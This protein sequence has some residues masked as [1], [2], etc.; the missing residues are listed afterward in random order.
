MQDCNFSVSIFSSFPCKP[1]CA[2]KNSPSFCNSLNSKKSTR[3]WS[4]TSAALAFSSR[5]SFIC[6]SWIWEIPSASF[7]KNLNS[8][9][10]TRDRSGISAAFSFSLRASFICKSWIWEIPSASFSNNL[11][12]KLLT[13]D[14]SGI[15]AAFSFSLRVSFICKSWICFREMANSL[16]LASSVSCKSAS[17]SSKPVGESGGRVNWSMPDCNAPTIWGWSCWK[18]SKIFSATSCAI[19]HICSIFTN[20]FLL[21]SPKQ[22][23]SI[24]TELLQGLVN[25]HILHCA[26]LLIY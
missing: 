10:L 22:N 24:S 8:K 17:R 15:S 9:L 14:R 6:K 11:N 23:M 3:N 12:S 1:C 13:R 25:V 26:Q 21:P 20:W 5:T 18:W 19:N 7:S 4:G 2:A 16:S